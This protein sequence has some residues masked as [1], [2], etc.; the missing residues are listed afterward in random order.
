MKNMASYFVENEQIFDKS[1]ITG[2]TSL[3]KW[4]DKIF[5]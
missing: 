5:C 2:R 4:V 1:K 3:R